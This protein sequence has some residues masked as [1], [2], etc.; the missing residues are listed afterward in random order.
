MASV[1]SCEGTFQA[2]VTVHV[3]TVPSVIQPR[4]NCPPP[5][6]PL[7][8][9]V[10]RDWHMASDEARL[11]VAEPHPSF[12]VAEPKPMPKP[13]PSPLP[14]PAEQVQDPAA[15]PAPAPTRVD[16]LLPTPAELLQ[17]PASKPAPAPV[18]VNVH[19]PT[20]AELL[21]NPA[22]KL[23]PAPTEVEVT[24]PTPAEPVQEPASKPAPAAEPGLPS[25]L[26]GVA[27]T[28]PKAAEPVQEPASKPAPTPTG[29]EVT[30]PKPAEPVQE[31]EPDAKPAEKPKEE[32]GE[33][34]KPN[35]KPAEKPKEEA[36]EDAKPAE[37]AGEDPKP[38]AKPAEKPKEEAGQDPKPDAKPG[39]PAEKPKEEAGEDA[40]PAEEAGEEPAADDPVDASSSS[41]PSSEPEPAAK[42]TTTK[43]AA[44]DSEDPAIGPLKSI[45]DI[46]VHDKGRLPHQESKDGK[47][48]WIRKSSQDSF[49]EARKLAAELTRQIS[50]DAAYT[51]DGGPVQLSCVQSM[52]DGTRLVWQ[53]GEPSPV[54]RVR[55]SA[56]QLAPV[57]S[58]LETAGRLASQDYHVI[59]V[60]AAS[61]YHLGGGFLTGGRHALEES[62]CMRSTLFESLVQAQTL[63]KEQQVT[64]PDNCRP[65]KSHDGHGWKC[66]IPPTGC[67]VSPDVEIF[68]GAT[69]EGYPF[70]TAEEVR[71]MTIISVAMPNCNDKVK[72]APVDA[73]AEDESRQKVILQKLQSLLWAAQSDLEQHG[74]GKLGALV[75]PDVGCGVYGNSHKEV[76]AL[77]NQA[78]LDYKNVFAEIHIA[79]PKEFYE[80][81]AGSK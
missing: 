63:A 62:I 20:P 47:Y 48:A 25:A 68:R 59:A 30:L 27:G 56:W 78:M 61:A 67:I 57:G 69:D 71:K 54:Q 53:A 80:A 9:P 77:L 16:V 45:T 6:D 35:A 76:G 8:P 37:E 39:K 33:D 17:D 13:E 12:K 73:P 44:D 50:K 70:Y 3:A 79:G 10:G 36:G 40:K 64:A 2:T 28:W 32:A 29:V 22:S 4:L 31:A 60:N 21:Q 66:H 1:T 23:A 19:L 49:R 58:L 46:Y 5:A 43:P 42:K 52:K 74:D 51:F 38:D 41:D 55:K 72:D 14:K 11:Q 24:L 26:T 15:Q 75:I 18:E 81:A 7:P 34:A 65:L